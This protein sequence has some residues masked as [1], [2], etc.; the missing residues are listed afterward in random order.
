VKP[1]DVAT[2]LR[3]VGRLGV[4]GWFPLVVE[5][6]HRRTQP[7]PGPVVEEVDGVT[8][9]L[10]LQEY[11]QRRVFYGAYERAE[12]ALVRKL[13]RAGDVMVDVGANVGFFT[14]RAA[15]AVGSGGRVYALEP[16]PANVAALRRNVELN[17]FANV[18]VM[19]VAVAALP[20]TLV[21]GLEDH[22][23]T[24]LAPGR[25]GTSGNY[26]EGGAG[27]RVEV[28][29]VTLDAVLDR[30]AGDEP[31]RVL[32]IDVEGGEPAALAGMGRR[33]RGDAPPQAILM[34]LNPAALEARG[35]SAEATAGVL[36]AAG[37][38]L[39][40]IGFGG[41]LAPYRSAASRAGVV[42]LIALQPGVRP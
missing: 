2:I 20:G 16:V 8:M 28:E 26:T 27:A 12:L 38:E 35:A 31:V 1:T 34:E 42:N 19:A 18:E 6:V 24:D 3:P 37:Y 22:T 4:P 5:R 10:D 15:A 17:G 40:R 36:S 11:V 25:D 21:L 23:G 30:V 7:A 41:R 14:L 33:L 32:K 39:F 9:S 13:L 29:A